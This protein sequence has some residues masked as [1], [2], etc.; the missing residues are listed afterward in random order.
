MANKDPK[1]SNIKEIKGID[2]DHINRQ[3]S[4]E[5]KGLCIQDTSYR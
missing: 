1:P 3:N 2:K 5:N 4:K